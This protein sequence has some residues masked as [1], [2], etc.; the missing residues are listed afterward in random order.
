MISGLTPTNAGTY[1]SE[2]THKL[3]NDVTPIGVC[4]VL[5]T[6]CS[7]AADDSELPADNTGGDSSTA[8]TLPERSKSLTIAIN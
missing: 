6:F 4:C 2:V 5:L 1:S 7:L 3:T 8:S